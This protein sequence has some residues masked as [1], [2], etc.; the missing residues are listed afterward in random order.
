M[1]YLYDTDQ[2]SFKGMLNAKEVEFRHDPLTV[3]TKLDFSLC[4]TDNGSSG[5]VLCYLSHLSFKSRNSTFV[6]KQLFSRNLVSNHQAG[7]F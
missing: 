5:L 4:K 7:K 6:M 3:P 2:V 1:R